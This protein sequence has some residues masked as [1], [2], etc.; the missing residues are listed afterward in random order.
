MAL[1]G[2]YTIGDVANA[3]RETASPAY[4]DRIPV[5]SDNNFKEF[6]TGMNVPAFFNE[7]SSALINRIG[8]TV[9]RN[10][11][12]ENPL[13]FLKK[14]Q[15]A[16]GETVQEIY[17]ALID[18]QTWE[19]ETS[20][21]DAGKIFKTEKP[22]VYASYHII[23][24]EDKYPVSYNRVQISKAFTSAQAL[25]QFV[26][27]IY[28]RLYTSD[29]LDEYLYM[30]E[31]LKIYD[32]KGLF[33]YVEIDST[34]PLEEL[35]IQVRSMSNK[36]TF[37]SDKY[38]GMGVQQHAPKD[39][40]VILISSD[41]DATIDV[42]V[43]ASAFNMDKQTFLARRIVLDDLGVEG[44]LMALVSKDWFM[45]YD[46]LRE[47]HSL[48]NPDT[49]EMKF[50]YHVHQV[51]SASLLENAVL[52]TTKTY[53][54]PASVEVDEVVA[55]KLAGTKGSWVTLSPEVQD[56]DGLAVD[57]NQAVLYRL[58]VNANADT[59]FEGNR[60]YID[61]RQDKNFNVRVSALHDK[62]VFLD[63]E[64]EVA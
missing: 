42:T 10:R 9:L 7:F 18:A 56:A 15:L 44:A 39:E 41:L 50:F 29:M 30:K 20:E 33:H 48:E 19:S 61:L 64:V 16:M 53:N 47:I 62:D 60:L 43:L 51:I 63:F 38:T 34:K 40:Q 6:A 28:E 57:V 21:A 14:G 1:V 49:L 52:F 36:F 24:R 32:T 12:W 4:Q 55:G 35:I 31:L 22:D 17:T 37:I 5:L 23:N 3:I 46:R 8:L 54:A 58:D 13:A 45:V 2:D 11:A 25:E 27:S 59:K 26:L